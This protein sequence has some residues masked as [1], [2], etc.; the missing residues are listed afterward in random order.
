MTRTLLVVVLLLY[1]PTLLLMGGILNIVSCG[2]GGI[3]AVLG[4]IV[5]PGEPSHGHAMLAGL[6][7]GW[8]HQ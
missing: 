5:R 8:G 3:C 2:G 1:L 6:L 7:V 4:A